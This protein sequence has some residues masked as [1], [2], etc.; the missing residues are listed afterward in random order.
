MKTYK[1]ISCRVAGNKGKLQFLEQILERVQELSDF[2]FSLGVDAWKDQK[3]LYHMCREKFPD[4]H[5]K[6][7]QKFISL[8]APKKGRKLPKKPIKAGIYMDQGQVVSRTTKPTKEFTYWLTV[9]K[10]NFPLVGRHLDRYLTEGTEV[11]LIHIHKKNGKLYCNLFL[12]KEVPDPQ[13]KN[14]PPK[15]VAIDVNYRRIVTSDNKFYHMKI[16]AHRKLE[17]KKNK[18]K[19][20]NLA[21]Y[22]KD[23]L[24]KLTTKIANDLQKRGVDVLL[25]EDL[26]HLRKSACRKAGTSKGK[27]VNYIINSFPYSMFQHMLTY[28]CLDRGIKVVK[29]SPQY[30]SKRCSRCGSLNTKRPTQVEFVCVDCGLHLDADLNGARNIVGAY[31]ASQWAVVSPALSQSSSGR[32][33]VPLGIQ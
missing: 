11:K 2:V 21:N 17:R 14:D 32:K 10:K 15:V 29:V 6:L 19:H 20:R 5:S 8:Y 3:T 13:P 31:M 28:K 16:L 22:T 7:L 25:L 12:V 33:L 1:T 18:Q 26:R 27:L 9:F 24:H 30:T 23:F 4:L